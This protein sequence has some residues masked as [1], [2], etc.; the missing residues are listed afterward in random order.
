MEIFNTDDGSKPFEFAVCKRGTIEYVCESFDDAV[1]LAEVGDLII[2]ISGVIE[3]SVKD[4][5]S[6][7]YF[8]TVRAERKLKV[9]SEE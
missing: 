1:Q 7:K 9:N 4:I 6:G 3:K 2:R 8:K 5:P